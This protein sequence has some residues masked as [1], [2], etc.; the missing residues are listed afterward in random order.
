MFKNPY[1]RAGLLL[2]LALP[3]FIY[4]Q[5]IKPEW[6][7][8]LPTSNNER[9][10]GRGEA[11]T[12][13]DNYKQLAERN[14]LRSIAME[15]N[16]EISGTSRRHMIEINDISQTEF[17]DEFIVST[18]ANFQGLE[19][20]GEY[21]DLNK[22][23]YYVLWEY[24]KERHKENIQQAAKNAI[25]LFNEYL[26]LES[27]EILDKL[28][29]LVK[30]YEKMYF[31]YGEDVYV[32]VENRKVN[33]K[34]EVPTRINELLRHI[35]I[36]SNKLYFKGVY[37]KNIDKPLK[38][39]VDMYLPEPIG[40]TSGYGLPLE[41]FFKY[42]S[43]IFSDERVFVND[44][45]DAETRI[46]K[47]TD[48]IKNQ[49]VVARIDL[50]ALK[51][52]DLEFSLL[53]KSLDRLGSQTEIVFNIEV[54]LQ[55]N[56]RI[57][58]YVKSS[59][60]MDYQSILV[61]NQLFEEAFNKIS[62]FE[63]VD[64][65]A[66]DEIFSNRGYTNAD[67]CDNEQ[68][69][70]EIGTVLNVDKF[71]LVDLIYVTRE[72]EISC[73]MRYT[74]VI[75][76]RSEGRQ[77]YNTKVNKSDYLSSLRLI[78][79]SWVS[80]F[81]QQLNPARVTFTSNAAD[82]RIFVDGKMYAFSPLVD[83]EFDQNNYLFEFKALGYESKK[84]KLDLGSNVIIN[85]HIDLKKKTPFKAFRKSL[86]FPGLGQFYSV[87][88]NN[89][90]RKST[91]W[92]MVAGGLAT[93]AGSVYAWNNYNQSLEKYNNTKELYD[94]QTTI[95]G[96]EEYSA[97]TTTDNDNML[98]QYTIAVTFSSVTVGYWLANA[99]EAMINMPKY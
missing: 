8:N 9:Y 92:I 76:Q 98:N 22:S 7:K 30:C 62:D 67:V 25:E 28:D 1:K 69:R 54:S 11:S 14:A 83:E 12:K 56:D 73:S 49:Q 39:Q 65:T 6:V 68:C 91:G 5:G 59:E 17:T 94:Q 96:I 60:G 63:I 57:A 72:N 87:D 79:P 66:A 78:I 35:K 55:R 3:F 23:T 26:W 27:F 81:Y 82:A 29:K 37:S 89:E 58:V 70:I 16:T 34:Y 42:G 45:G 44:F 46:V 50:K 36:N 84:K 4:G 32:N 40:K 20:K 93:F 95:D 21:D 48:K 13:K 41:F 19:K 64:R 31:L 24:P 52:K 77:N 61:V 38:V 80:V 97:K 86:L 10:I 74:D 51:S 43:G 85:E 90:N 75:K 18:L 71:V 88:E 33:L 15:I 2:L 47:I 53:D 99:I